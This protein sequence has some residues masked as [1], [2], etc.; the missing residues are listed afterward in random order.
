MAEA[1]STH[2]MAIGAL[3]NKR[4]LST[5]FLSITLV[6]YL[7]QY[8]LLAVSAKFKHCVLQNQKHNYNT[9]VKELQN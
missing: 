8:F 1:G 4:T 2:Q 3:K 9:F 5:S 7:K 6:L